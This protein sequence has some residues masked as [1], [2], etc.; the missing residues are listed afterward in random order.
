MNRIN[1][2][3]LLISI[4]I[5]L[6]LLESGLRTFTV[7][8]IHGSFNI[9]HH[10]YLGYTLNPDLPDVD[11]NGFRNPDN[12]N[13]QQIDILA[14]GDSHTQGFNVSYNQSWPYILAGKTKKNVY[15]LGVG[16]YGY[17]HYAYLLQSG[18]AENA[19]FIL[20]ALFPANDIR[21][22]ICAKIPANFYSSLITSGIAKM[23]CPAAENIRKN[24]TTT[25]IDWL[26]QHTAIVS[27][28]RYLL[29]KYRID[30]IEYYNVSGN[31][32][33]KSH[34]QEWTTDLSNPEVNHN[35]DAS[36]RLFKRA[37]ISRSEKGKYFG[38]MIVPSKKLVLYSWAANQVKPV[39]I[40]YSIDNEKALIERYIHDLRELGIPV[41]D[42]TPYVTMAF[43]SDILDGKIFYP[44]YDNHPLN[45][46][47]TAYAEAAMELVNNI[48][49]K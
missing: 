21:P 44:Y 37:Y 39:T 19:D 48:Q 32:I 4:S 36:I 3:V 41:V 31:L 11:N 22:G 7:F 26:M 42:A 43:T 49:I 17:P 25:F 5:S 18:F 33:K 47:Y 35:Y 27:I 46:G 2:I 16:G 6:L 45:T 15:N 8:P 20:I 13:K 10:Q 28:T 1:L 38:V 24:K 14:I 29:V 30:E 40:N 23:P 12:I 34:T 9:S